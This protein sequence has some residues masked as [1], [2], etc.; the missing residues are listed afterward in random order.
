MGVPATLRTLWVAIK[1]LMLLQADSK[2]TDP[3]S[4]LRVFARCTELVILLVLSCSGSFFKL[5]TQVMLIEN[6]FLKQISKRIKLY[7][8]FSIWASYEIIVCV[9]NLNVSVI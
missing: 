4:L 1:D 6:N 8:N 2:D 7:L 3:P 5:L 9:I